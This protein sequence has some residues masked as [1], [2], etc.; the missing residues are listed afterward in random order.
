MQA[1]RLIIHP[2]KRI[3]SAAALTHDT[4]GLTVADLRKFEKACREFFKGFEGQNF[5]DLSFQH[6]QKMVDAHHLSI[7]D[8]FTLYSRKLKDVK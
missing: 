7:D 8:L 6:I 5:G 2:A 4:E 1:K 3:E